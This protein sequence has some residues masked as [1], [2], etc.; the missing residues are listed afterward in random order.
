MAAGVR[1]VAVQCVDRCAATVGAG[2]A[3]PR[4]RGGEAHLRLYAVGG[5]H[6]VSLRKE[7]KQ[8]RPNRVSCN[9]LKTCAC[10]Q[11]RYTAETKLSTSQQ[12]PLTV[13]R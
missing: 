5:W 8:G 1:V 12:L 11:G 3:R 7:L 4:E 2:R 6:A 9:Y 13:L 10:L